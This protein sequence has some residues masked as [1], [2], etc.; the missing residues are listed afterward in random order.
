MSS[1]V[2]ACKGTAVDRTAKAPLRREELRPQLADVRPE[3]L[4]L[5][6]RPVQLDVVQVRVVLRSVG[7]ITQI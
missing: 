3:L 5:V 7:S 6:R 2:I 1:Q 4:E